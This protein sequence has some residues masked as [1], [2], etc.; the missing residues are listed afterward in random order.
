MATQVFE[1]ERVP[2]YAETLAMAL[3]AV[4]QFEEA[5]EM[6]RRVLAEAERL[7]RSGDAERLVRNLGLY[8]SGRA[9]CGD[10]TDILPPH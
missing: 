6:Q 2:P 10:P 9:C 5:V 4:G 1:A 3:A 7:G 8:R